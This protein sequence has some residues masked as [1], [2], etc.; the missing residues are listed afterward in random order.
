MYFY[1]ILRV[2]YNEEMK[3]VARCR[4]GNNNKLLLA[5]SRVATALDGSSGL[6]MAIITKYIT[7]FILLID[8]V[9]Q[10]AVSMLQK[11]RFTTST[12]AFLSEHK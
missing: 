7:K 1:N 8:I 10:W 2:E 11:P 5:K 4:V 9:S 12:T 6:K 3:H